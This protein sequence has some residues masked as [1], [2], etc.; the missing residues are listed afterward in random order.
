MSDTTQNTGSGLGIV[1]GIL[2]LVWL[3]NYL[4]DKKCPFCG[5]SNPS[6]AV[7]CSNCGGS[8]G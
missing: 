7:L 4:S 3:A 2:G 6:N 1:L 8:L 5:Y